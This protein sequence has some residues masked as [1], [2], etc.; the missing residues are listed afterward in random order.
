MSLR[1]AGVCAATAFAV[2]G[3]GA[4]SAAAHT[5][6]S[7]KVARQIAE[8]QKLK[9]SL[10]PAERKLDSRLAV[11]LRRHGADGTAL[12][13]LRA[14]TTGADLQ[15]RLD[16]VGG[17]VRSAKRG[18]IR[19]RLPLRSL[20]E[21]ASWAAVRHVGESRGWIASAI[22]SEGDKAHAAEIARTGRRVTGI[23]TKIC[24][25]SDGVDSLAESQAAGELRAVDVLP[26][27]E[28]DGDEGTAML[29]ILHDIAP[30]A[31]LGFATA[32]SIF[33]TDADF[34]ANIRALRFDAGCDILLDDILYFNE[35]P[36]QDG[37]IARA[38]NDVTADG[39]LYFS[40]AGNE[41][42]TLDG[43]SGNYEAD[44]VDSGQGVGKF[45]GA[46]HDFDPGPGVQV[47]E[48]ISPDSDEGVPVTLFWANRLGGAADDYDLYL[49]DR[50]GNLVDFSQDVQDGNDDPYERVTTPG[51]GGN[52]LRLAV[53]RFKGA[54]R[55][56]Q[57]SA[58]RG[59]YEDS[60][61]G[62]VA[63]VS[64]GVTRGH[65]A[66]ADA[67]SVAAAPAAAPYPFDLE[68]GDPPNPAGPFPNAFTAA[69]RPE[70]FTSDGPRRMFF[71][72]D[73][74]PAEVVRA[75]PDITAAD[76]VR[77]SVGAP[78]DPFFGTSASAPHAAAIAALVLSGNPG[79]TTAD[80]RDAFNSTALDLAPAGVDGRTGHGL[81]RADR[82][83]A[84]TGAT[85]QPLVRAGAPTVTPVT[86]DG[87]AYVEPGEAATVA[88]PVTNV[89]DGTATGVSVTAS[90]T[91][92]Q[93]TLTPRAQSYGNLAAGATRSRNFRLTLPAG[94]PLGKRVPIAVRVTF[95]GVLSPTSGT[96]TVKTGRPAAA[97]TTF[98]YAGAP[99]AIPDNAP[100]GASVTI[101]VSGLGYAD[102]L[103]FSIDGT[104]CNT[105]TPSTT[106][107]LDH[108]FVSDLTATLTAPG[109]GS[110]R[111]FSGDGGSGNNLCQVVFDDAAA[112]PFDGVLAARAPFTGTWRPDDALDPLLTDSVDGDWTLKIVDAALR[113][114]GSI[115]AVSLHLTGF[116]SG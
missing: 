61:D 97:A 47:W 7:I 37:I 112:T 62:L 75:K 91:D 25:L 45:A 57:L 50:A 80:L 109:G 39:A 16:A 76:G 84:H 33:S 110:V 102:K 103:T 63:H 83:L 22:V 24:A 70:R 74:T 15:K 85:P 1:L 58:L 107:G 68:P 93:V 101:P 89:G 69:Q 31:E 6:L 98:A 35:S 100:A 8:L 77:T 114:T 87:D 105:A 23:G 38:V 29:E 59:R 49:F 66:A 36:F 19:V 21:V 113:D 10:S 20:K 12:V 67:F 73:G 27:Q 56:F 106:V 95:A 34:A 48:P 13:D 28:G 65:S 81:I 115:R 96:V 52:G 17:R 14:S 18:T 44:F 42:N 32:A 46:A 26:D 86:G 92:A 64:P 111:L 5:G 60:T 55:Y 71:A 30:N 99:V 54:V 72:P 3:L 79:A 90:T 53:V 41:G 11:K 82:V 9:R 88:I 78:F 94:Y 4:Q 2:F 40:S 51:A 104:T 116:E 43:T 108:S